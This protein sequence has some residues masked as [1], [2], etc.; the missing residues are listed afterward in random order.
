MSKLSHEEKK[1]LRRDKI[2]GESLI[3]SAVHTPGSDPEFAYEYA[4]WALRSG[5]WV[6]DALILFALDMVASL[7]VFAA[8]VSVFENAHG[9]TFGLTT[10]S[11]WITTTSVVALVVISSYFIFQIHA[12]AG[13]PGM[14]AN[15]L[16][17]VDGQTGSPVSWG[18]S[19]ARLVGMLLILAAAPAAS[20]PEGQG[21]IISISIGA[22][23][24]ILWPLWDKKNRM[25]HDLIG[26][27]VVLRVP[28]NK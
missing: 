6:Y 7:L 17:C 23:L 26:S 2:T 27:T 5:S 16:I 24:D 9:R 21:V 14:R 12:R 8:L 1:A 20:T 10:E 18:S 13:T 22:L 19:T 11:I 15:H 3:A 4:S 25:L 28:K